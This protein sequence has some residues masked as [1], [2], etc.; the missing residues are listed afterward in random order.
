M[1]L[2]LTHAEAA[3][4]HQ[5]AKGTPVEFEA[6]CAWSRARNDLDEYEAK[7][8]RLRELRAELKRRK[9]ASQ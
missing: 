1:E 2:L 7:L 3:D 5:A 9:E 8:D 4:A 6:L